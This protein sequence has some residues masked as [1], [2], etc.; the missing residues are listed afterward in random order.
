MLLQSE[1]TNVLQSAKVH[2]LAGTA[3]CATLV[4]GVGGWAATASV[5]E[6]VVS[7]GLVVVQSSNKLV[8]HQDGGT[9]VA[10]MVAEGDRVKAGDVVIRLD[11]K[12]LTTELDVMRKRIFELRARRTRLTAE[13]QGRA[14]LSEA[15]LVDTAGQLS[16][17]SSLAEIVAVQTSVFRSRRDTQTGR[18]AQLRERIKQLND[19]NDGL[20]HLVK[21]KASELDNL[22]TELGA[23]GTL[24]KDNLV[25]SARY[26]AVFRDRSRLEGEVAQVKA[27]LAR[28]RGRIAETELQMHELDERFRTEILGELQTI[29]GEYAQLV[30]RRSAAE[31]KVRR[32]EIKAPQSGRVHELAVRTIGGVVR[33]GETL[34]QIVPDTD[35]LVVDVKIRANDIDRI[36]QSMPA[37]V[38]FTGFNSR[39]T[40]ELLGRVTSIS[41]DQTVVSE[42]QQ[43]FFKARVVLNE[44]EVERL[45]G[46]SLLPG[47][48][49]EV[50]ITSGPRT[51]I[52]Y[53]MKPISDQMQRAMR[54]Q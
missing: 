39:T 42:N 18:R 47:M 36:S 31:D 46:R 49:S 35:Q 15:D 1:F 4:F 52:S 23:L 21:T 48:Q 45:N 53:L 22:T 10:L 16:A 20:G 43:P 25:S 50:L 38:R 2:T 33:S 3:V 11:G 9:V 27:D 8:Q 12:Q 5:D 40:P 6:A 34:L 19:E 7:P 51:V 32:L 14:S 54:E 29:E 26:N 44:G 37:R 17:D 24:K 13:L 41:A 30:E 28:N